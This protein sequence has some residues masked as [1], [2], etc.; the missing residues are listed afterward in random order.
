MTPVPEWMNATQ[1][2]LAKIGGITMRR[3]LMM[4]VVLLL[5]LGGTVAW[6]NCAWVLWEDVTRLTAAAERH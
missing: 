4:A 6:S 1:I 3:G 2:P 5:T